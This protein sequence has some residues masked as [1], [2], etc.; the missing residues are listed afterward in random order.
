MRANNPALPKALTYF[1]AFSILYSLAQDFSLYLQV[2][3]SP[4]PAG[5][6]T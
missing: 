1:I 4:Q 3:T 5:P 2:P 6:A